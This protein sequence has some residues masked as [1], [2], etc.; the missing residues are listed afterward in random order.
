MNLFEKKVSRSHWLFPNQSQRNK[1]QRPSPP[2][3][4]H[5][6]HNREHV[7]KP[8]S[9]A[10]R[11]SSTCPK[12]SKEAQLRGKPICSHC[13][14]E[15]TSTV[16]HSVVKQWPMLYFSFTYMDHLPAWFSAP[17]RLCQGQCRRGL[18][19]RQSLQPDV[20]HQKPGCFKYPELSA[21]TDS[22]FMEIKLSLTYQGELKPPLK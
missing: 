3:Q 19:C 21:P 17:K 10:A 2:R 12:Q 1:N 18:V 7:T 15:A 20:S 5:H 4:K 16:N 13:S 22:A 9:A 11:I 6:K 8:Q 14:Q